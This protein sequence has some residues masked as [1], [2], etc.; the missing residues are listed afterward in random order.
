MGWK[1][2][3][4][5]LWEACRATMEDAIGGGDGGERD[6]ELHTVHPR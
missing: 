6:G 5:S 2:A 3:G 4:R 1:I